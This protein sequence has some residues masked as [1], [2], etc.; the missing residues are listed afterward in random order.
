MPR[1]SDALRRQRISATEASRSFSRLLDQVEGGRRFV[2]RRHGR[3]VGVLAPPETGD[4][5]ASE[6]LALL[7]A[8]GRVLLD[9]R[10]G[11]D[12]MEVVSGEP[13]E[14]RPPWDS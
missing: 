2:I 5:K 7:R 1:K 6:C 13:A 4:R 9:D 12:L 11:R 14:E 3:D 8:R 10:F